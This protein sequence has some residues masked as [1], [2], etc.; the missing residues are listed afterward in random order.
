[1]SGPAQPPQWVQHL[2]DHN[3]LVEGQP[4][5]FEAVVAPIDD[6]NLTVTW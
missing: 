3:D 1:V 4:A 2:R 5:H 6:A